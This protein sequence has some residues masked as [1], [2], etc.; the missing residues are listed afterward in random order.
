MEQHVLKSVNKCLN[1]NISTYSKTSSGG[2]SNLY[3]I[4][5]FSTPALI[6]HLWQLKTVAF[7]HCCLICGALL[8]NIYLVKLSATA[9]ILTHRYLII[10]LSRL[11]RAMRH[12]QNHFYMCYHRCLQSVVSCHP[13]KPREVGVVISCLDIPNIFSFTPRLHEQWWFQFLSCLTDFARLSVQFCQALRP[14][15]RYEFFYLSV[16]FCAILVRS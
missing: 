3:L 4:C 5:F 10:Y 14:I 15:L 13:R 16:R 7:L 1:T 2:S 6:R 9:T 12:K 11:P 8:A